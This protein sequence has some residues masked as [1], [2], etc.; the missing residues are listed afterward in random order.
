MLVIAQRGVGYGLNRWWDLSNQSMVSF[1]VQTKVIFFFFFVMAQKDLG[2]MH[3]NDI[4]VY[5]LDLVICKR[6]D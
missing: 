3:K 5:F 1:C 6:D 2:I 4:K